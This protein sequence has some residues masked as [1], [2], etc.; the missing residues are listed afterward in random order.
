MGWM[1]Q[2]YWITSEISVT[3]ANMVHKAVFGNYPLWHRKDY[4]VIKLLK[5]NDKHRFAQIAIIFLCISVK[6]KTK[7]K[8]LNILAEKSNVVMR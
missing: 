5:P 1:F 8:T 7:Q 3:S 4:F 6:I 2:D